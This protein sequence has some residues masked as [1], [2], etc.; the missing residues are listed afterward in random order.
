ML[1]I[2]P[3]ELSLQ[4]DPVGYMSV[5]LHRAKGWLAEAQNIESVRDAKAIAVGYEAV[6]KEKELAF[7]AQ[8][9]ATEIVRRC[10]RRIGQ[11]VREGQERGEIRRQG[12]SRITNMESSTLVF[13]D[14]TS[15][16][17]DAY[18]M[19]ATSDAG[20]DQAVEEAKETGDWCWVD[21][22]C[23]GWKCDETGE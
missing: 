7:D 16:R 13:Q 4:S 18:A 8:L 19:A 1:P 10:E 17:A 5:V 2:E 21:V 9:S 22:C 23:C 12:Q 6:I 3:D 15:E 11:L 14:G 20:F